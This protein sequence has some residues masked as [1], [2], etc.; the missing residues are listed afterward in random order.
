MP[1]PLSFVLATPCISCR[2]VHSHNLFMW[3]LS[4]Y[5][6]PCSPKWCLQ[7][8]KNQQSPSIPCEQTQPTS[9][10]SQLHI[11]TFLCWFFLRPDPNKEEFSLNINLLINSTSNLNL[12]RRGFMRRLWGSKLCESNYESWSEVNKLNIQQIVGS[13]IYMFAVTWRTH[14][15]TP[16]TH[17]SSIDI[18]QVEQSKY[19]FLSNVWSQCGYR[20]ERFSPFYIIDLKLIM[21]YRSPTSSTHFIFNIN[22]S[23]R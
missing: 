2:F 10:Y 18:C 20:L 11:S 1:P 8:T 17:Q 14:G 3:F 5:P 23:S 7:I 16:L 15:S 12:A 21:S 4:F 22:R 6:C 13:R 9:L 19:I